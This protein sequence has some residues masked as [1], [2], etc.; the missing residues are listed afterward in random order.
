MA[1]LDSSPVLVAPDDAAA[2]SPSESQPKKQ[3]KGTRFWMIF[4]ALCVSCFLS[5]I[6][7]TAVSTALP[8]MAADLSGGA[9]FTWIGSAY[10]LTSTALI[11]WTGGLATIF[12][13]RITMMASLIFFAVGSAI[14]GAA[15]SMNVA[16]VGRSLQGVGGGEYHRFDFITEIVIVDLVPLA[17]RGAF[18]GILGATWSIASAI[19]PPIGGAFANAGQWRWLFYMNIPL[20]GI[21]LVFVVLFLKIKTP[22]TTLQEKLEQMDYLNVV[23]VAGST[24]TILGLTW[25]GSAYPW[26]SY[27]VLVPLIIGI[28]SMVA[29]IFLEKRFAKYPTIPFQI[30]TN[31]TSLI[32][33]FTTFLH[34]IISIC[35]I[36]YL[37][38]YFQSTKE[39]T[40]LQSGIDLFSLAFTVAPFGII[41]GILIT[42]TG[43]YK[44]QNLAGW[45]LM[46]VG[47]GLMTLLQANS[48]K[49][50]WVG[51]PIIVGCALGALYAATNFPVLAPLKPSDQA[52]AQAFYGFQRSF[53]QVFGIA[54]GSTILQNQ[55]IKKLPAEF[56]QTLE[57]TGSDAGLAFAA[58]PLISK[59]SEP[60]KTQVR[61]AFADSLRTIWQTSIGLSGLGLIVAVFMKSYKLV[62][63]TDEKWGME[64]KK[65]KVVDVEKA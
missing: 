63:V 11:P 13:R 6:D 50:A 49:G 15:P 46:M 38:V 18:F 19:G 27:Q 25:G 4:V 14:T 8:T 7:L 5:A 22:D 21:A 55:L 16:I 40:A 26:S 45:G 32:G 54:I 2:D 37:P 53:G 34:G 31:R 52:L 1:K 48:S 33:Y 9:D 56:F 64:E 10:A 65:A 59:L 36:Y 12:G 44:I 41:I 35:T 62:D 17:E 42:V 47:F 58:I 23:F 30:L 61:V 60:L 24:A 3:G 57:G 29:F 51:Y 39:A 28:M 43:H 20:C